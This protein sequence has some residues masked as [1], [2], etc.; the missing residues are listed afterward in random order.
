MDNLIFYKRKLFWIICGGPSIISIIYLFFLAT[1]RYESESIVR[2]YGFGNGAGT[3]GG[4]ILGGS[5][6][7]GAYIFRE[8]I[9]GWDCFSHLS[10]KKLTGEWQ[11]GD[12]LTRYGSISS[13]FSQN[14]MRLWA[15]YRSHVVVS[16]D[17]ESGLVKVNVDSYHSDFS[18]DLNKT[19]I[20]Y[21]RKHLA[22]AGV[23]AYEN[24]R[25]RIEGE[26]SRDRLKL[27]AAFADMQQF[28]KEHGIA[29][30]DVVYNRTLELLNHYQ[31]TRVTLDSRASAAQYFAQRSQE[32]AMLK[33]QIATLDHQIEVQSQSVS[34]TLSPIYTQYSSLKQNISEGMNVVRLDNQNIQDIEQLETR[35]S[36]H[37]DVVE[38]TVKPTDPMMPR[39]VYWSIAILVLSFLLYVI[40]K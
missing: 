8:T 14:P 34:K 5:A 29:D 32:L 1:P 23:L 22:D 31:E 7:P 12:F 37:V 11:K 2:V 9:T 16:I 4:S 38:N 19:V 35:S 27:A 3:G 33:A 15:Y 18:S 20:E 13:L 26:L 6:S 10:F 21:A 25:S 36:Y 24:E 39:A 30:Y 17:D 28:Q 40:I